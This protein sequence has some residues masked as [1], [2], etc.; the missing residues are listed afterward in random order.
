MSN[1]GEVIGII[2]HSLAEKEIAHQNLSELQI[3]D[4]MHERKAMMEKLSEG[5][6]AMPGGFGTFEE[7]CEMITWCQLG[8]HRKPCAV[9]NVNGYYD[10]LLEMFDNST[11]MGFIRPEHRKL[12]ISASSVDELMSGMYRFEAPAYEKWIDRESS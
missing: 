7:L 12:V 5:F 2:P 4:S 11:N 6:I 10:G 9:L 1:D 3:V 8:I